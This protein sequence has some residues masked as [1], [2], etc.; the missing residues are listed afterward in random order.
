MAD[1]KLATHAKATE[2]FLSK[3]DGVN[4][5]VMDGTGDAQA[6]AKIYEARLRA[7]SPQVLPRSAAG[8]AVFDMMLIGVG[9]D[10]HVGSL[11]EP[12]LPRP[13]Y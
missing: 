13:L 2:L 10:G 6:E 5:I 7:L 3:W 4:A 11:C 9:D 1:A 8:T 12:H